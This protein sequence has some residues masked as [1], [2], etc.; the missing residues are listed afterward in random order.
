MDQTPARHRPSWPRVLLAA[1]VTAVIV[2]PAAAWASQ[3]FDDVPNSNIFSDD[4]DWMADNGITLGCNPPA[5]DEYCPDENVTREQMA[6][7]MRRLAT[8]RVVDADTVDG[9]N[10]SAFLKASAAAGFLKTSDA[11]D[12]LSSELDSFVPIVRFTIAE[13]QGSPG[14]YTVRS[15]WRSPA[16][17]APSATWVPAVNGG[18]WDIDLPGI[19][20]TYARWQTECTAMD[21][22]PRDVVV[23][24]LNGDMTITMYDLDNNNVQ[25][26]V[27]CTVY[28]AVS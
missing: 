3:Q 27:S 11:D 9:R 19:N 2:A 25:D 8:K 4:I 23:G 28:N 26:D 10:A 7:F 5:N 17:G 20:F 22:D 13:N 18:S 1:V 12:F 15:D 16:T 24:Q 21:S 14:T 6:A